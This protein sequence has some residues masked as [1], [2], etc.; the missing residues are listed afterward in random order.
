MKKIWTDFNGPNLE[1][2]RINDNDLKHFELSEGEKIILYTE[3]I[4]VEAVIE[5]DNE[6]GSWVGKFVSEV[7]TV[8]NYYR[9]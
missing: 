1:K 5:Y 7:I 2:L 3:D 9:A 6:Q 4:Q 8:S